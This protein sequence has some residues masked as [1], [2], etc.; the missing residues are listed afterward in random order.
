[1][2][3]FVT[4]KDGEKRKCPPTGEWVDKLDHTHKMECYSAIKNK[5][6]LKHAPTWA[7][8]L[9][10]CTAG[11]KKLESKGY[12]LCGFIYDDVEKAEK[13]M[14]TETRLVAF[15][16]VRRG[17]TAKSQNGAKGQQRLMRMF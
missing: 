3:L 7:S 12:S 14:G 17:P 16:G 6:L 9:M 11:R 2:A 10:K 4:A 15:K 1:M 8:L 13:T 5:P